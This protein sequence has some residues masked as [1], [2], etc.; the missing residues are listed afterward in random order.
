VIGLLSREYPNLSFHVTTFR[1]QIGDSVARERAF[2][3][4][5]MVL[6]GLALCLAAVGIYG[7]LAYFVEQRRAEFGIRIALGATPVNIRRLVYRQSVSAL[8]TGCAAGFLLALWGAKFTRAMLFGI[9]P[10]QPEAYVAVVGIVGAIAV[11][12]T[13]V[14]A[15][16]GARAECVRLLRSE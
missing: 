3:M 14:P 16:R 15:A 12:A 9:T 13:L 7:V 8:A 2:A 11:V 10:A 1:A 6:G 5:F 4:I